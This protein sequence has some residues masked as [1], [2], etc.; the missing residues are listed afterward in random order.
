MPRKDRTLSP[1]MDATI[2]TLR[3]DGLSQRAIYES[4][5]DTLEEALSYRDVRASLKRSNLYYKHDAAAARREGRFPRPSNVNE[6]PQRTSAYRKRREQVL[7][8]DKTP[9]ALDAFNRNYLLGTMARQGVDPNLISDVSM[10][11][12]LEDIYDGLGS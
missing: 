12:S 6:P 9:D 8:V 2:A 1:N 4:L 10:R 11:Q 7:S 5:R 3:I